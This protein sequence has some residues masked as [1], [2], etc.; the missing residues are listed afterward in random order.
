MFHDGDDWH[1]L[2]GLAPGYAMLDPTKCSLTTPGIEGGRQFAATGIPVAVPAAFLRARGIVNEKTSFYTI[3]LLVTAA[4]ERGKSGTLLSE[5][6][7]FKRAYDDGTLVRDA[8]PELAAAHR[9]R[10]GRVTVRQLCDEMHEL[11]SSSKADE[12]QRAVYNAEHEPEIVV[13]PAAGHTALVRG[14]VDLVP[15]DEL[16]GRVAAS[17][18][19]VYPPGIAIMVPGERFPADS[20]AV[21]YLRLFEESDNQFPGFESEMQGIFPRREADGRL[22]YYTYVVK[23]H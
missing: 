18:I 4:I 14:D 6:L 2:S 11:L 15:L 17:L 19:V 7:E 16:A 9:A 3:L 20:A 22:R 10:Y 12:L 5:L 23:E 1:D 8:L 21:A 13:S